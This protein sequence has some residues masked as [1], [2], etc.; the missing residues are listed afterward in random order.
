MCSRLEEAF[1]SGCEPQQLRYQRKC[2]FMDPERLIGYLEI[3]KTKLLTSG[4]GGFVEFAFWEHPDR[5]DLGHLPNTRPQM[6]RGT[7]LRG[8]ST[9]EDRRHTEASLTRAIDEAR[10]TLNGR[11]GPFSLIFLHGT[12]ED[13]CRDRA[14]EIGIG[15]QL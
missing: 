6:F 13:L 2:L 10:Y 12:M 8:C 15:F 11:R 5:E 4:S 9:S 14:L 3:Q 7:A 1:P